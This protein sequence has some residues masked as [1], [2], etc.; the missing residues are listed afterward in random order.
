MASPPAIF[1]VSLPGIF[2]R[3][4]RLPNCFVTP[5]R[6]ASFEP[7]TVSS[8]E[9]MMR[10]SGRVAQAVPGIVALLLRVDVMVSADAFDRSTG[11]AVAWVA[12][13]A[14]V[15]ARPAVASN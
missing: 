9:T 3:V 5:V 11:A 10:P 15:A 2:S 6:D 14:V 1:L 4:I 13:R 12:I 8:Y 7:V